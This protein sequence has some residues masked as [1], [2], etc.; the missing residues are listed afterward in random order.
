[1]KNKIILYPGEEFREFEIEKSLKFRY[2]ISNYGRLASFS[3]K[4]EEGNLLIGGKRDG[5][6]IFSYRFR[7]DGKLNYKY[8]F[9]YKLVAELFI[10]KTSEE[11]TYVLHL[12]YVR[13]NDVLR[14]LKWAT[15]EEMLA[16]GKK[17]PHVIRAKQRLLEHNIKADGKKLTSTQVIR[18]K[19]MLQNPERKNRLKMIAKEFNI[20]QTH[21]KRIETGENWGHIKV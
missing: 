8:R 10:P 14:N 4:I 9:F 6:N 1:M 13:D 18:I 19:K 5:Y 17:S 15:R 16:H 3:D 21:L 7:E 12:D 20:S 2:A 11:Q